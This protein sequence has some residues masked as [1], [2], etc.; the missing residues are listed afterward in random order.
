MAFRGVFA[1]YLKRLRMI[2]DEIYRHYSAE[3][4]FPCRSH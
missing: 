1:N 3:S 2:L 4:I